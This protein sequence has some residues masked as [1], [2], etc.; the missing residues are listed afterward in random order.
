MIDRAFFANIIS[1]GTT[2]AADNGY[3]YLRNQESPFG[4]SFNPNI[5]I[6]YHGAFVNLLTL[7]DDLVTIT[8][9]NDE[10]IAYLNLGKDFIPVEE[11]M[12]LIEN[13]KLEITLNYIGLNPN[14]L[15]IKK[16]ISLGKDNRVVYVC[17][18]FQALGRT[19]INNV[20]F[21]LADVFEI[22]D[23][24]VIQKS[25]VDSVDV[26]DNR[27]LIYRK[28]MLSNPI[29]ASLV[30]SSNLSSANFIPNYEIN[31]PYLKLSFNSKN[32][33]HETI[34]FAVSGNPV[35]RFQKR[36]RVFRLPD[37]LRN[38]N[39]KYI[40]VYETDIYTKNAY[41]SYKFHR[42]YSNWN[43]SIYEVP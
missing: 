43:Y 19:K 22:S 14:I 11:T 9:V 8:I 34:E 6:Y 39:V 42:V 2:I 31:K 30:L 10:R 40:V 41:E 3:V 16:R 32:S 29:I 33:T 17:Y 18:E 28:D 26:S 25:F 15:N 7:Q 21:Q 13:S 20:L 23:E 4:I 37:I 38:Y 24:E 35:G 27:I 1:T 36:L 5:S 12:L